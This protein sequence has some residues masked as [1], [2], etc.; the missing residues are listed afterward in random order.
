MN[1][2][3]Q[4]EFEKRGE[5]FMKQEK[6]DLAI[7]NFT[8]SLRIDSVEADCLHLRGKAY[9]A[10]GEFELAITDFTACIDRLGDFD[11]RRVANS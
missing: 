7:Q 9:L 3:Y 6:Y 10:I 5:E 1:Y 8:R 11:E 4:L 2:Q